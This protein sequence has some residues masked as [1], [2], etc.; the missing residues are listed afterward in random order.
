MKLSKLL[1]LTDD[2]IYVNVKVDKDVPECFKTLYEGEVKN[3]PEEHVINNAEVV[4][5][6][7]LDNELKVVVSMDYA[8]IVINIADK[9]KGG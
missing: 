1:K 8:T 7:P 4:S 5:F 2:S 3:I 6:E 9:L